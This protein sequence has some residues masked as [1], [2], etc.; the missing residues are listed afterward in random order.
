MITYLL[1]LGFHP[2]AVA[3]ELYNYKKETAIYKRRNNTQNNT[4]KIH[5]TEKKHTIQE[6][7]HNKNIKKHKS[8]NYNITK[9]SK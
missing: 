2:V 8:S 1:Q 3:V 4:K 5:K 6:H 7:E 9:I